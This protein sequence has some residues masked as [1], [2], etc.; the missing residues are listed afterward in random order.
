MTQYS[1][2][3]SICLHAWAAVGDGTSNCTRCGE[4]KPSACADCHGT[5]EG[6]PDAVDIS[7]HWPCPRCEGTG[8][9][10]K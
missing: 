10:S 4:P 9:V 3:V 5:G 8:E 6:N 1:N 7:D 2:S